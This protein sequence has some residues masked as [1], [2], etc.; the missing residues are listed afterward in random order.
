MKQKREELIQKLAKELFGTFR[1]LAPQPHF[2]HRGH[3]DHDH[4]EHHYGRGHM[5]LFFYL[6]KFKDKG[7]SVKDLARHLKVTSGA[8]T[9][10]VDHLVEKGLLKR[11]E[12]PTDR[13][14]QRVKFSET[15]TK[16]FNLFRSKYISSISSA[17]DNLTD[18]ELAQLVDLLAKINTPQKERG[19]RGINN[20][21][22]KYL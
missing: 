18:K 4:K 20:L 15:A 13:R 5:E 3:R 10:M 12:D 8:I 9:Q 21:S 22:K 11:E 7:V 6:R 1:S 17:F 16:K 14:I 2:W 19:Y